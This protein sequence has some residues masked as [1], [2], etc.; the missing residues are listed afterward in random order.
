MFESANTWWKG[1]FYS[2]RKIVK[3]SRPSVNKF[4]FVGIILASGWNQITLGERSC[5]VTMGFMNMVENIAQISGKFAC[6]TIVDHN[7]QMIG[8]AIMK[9]LPAKGVKQ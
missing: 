4:T 6:K 7:I 1:A 8:A 2:R 3:W 9:L 5:Q